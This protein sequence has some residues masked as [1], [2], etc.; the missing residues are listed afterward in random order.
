MTVP[1]SGVL[2]SLFPSEPPLAVVWDGL[3]SLVLVVPECLKNLDEAALGKEVCIAV[4]TVPVRVL[5]I[6][7]GLTPHQFHID[8]SSQ[9]RTKSSPF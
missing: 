5:G 7:A 6:N 4:V 2:L 9:S 3:T 8:D 1:T